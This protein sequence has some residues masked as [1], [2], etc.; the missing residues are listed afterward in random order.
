MTM[1]VTT[2]ALT[3]AMTPVSGRGC[4]AAA[5]PHEET[6]SR[7]TGPRVKIVRRFGGIDL[8]GLTRKTKWA[9]NRPFP[10]GQHGRNTRPG[11]KSDY[12]VRLEEKQKLR[13]YYG[14]R[15]RQLMRYMRQSV[16]A[17]GNTGENLLKVLESRLD[18]I[19]F[20]LGL[21]PTIPAARQ[22]V[23]HG[24]VTINGKKVDVASYRVKAGDEV[25]LRNK[26]KSQKLGAL[27]A[28]EP[29]L[30][31]PSHLE[32]DKK[33]LTGRVIDLPSRA[34]VPFELNEQLIVEYYSQRV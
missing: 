30:A 25:G 7:F 22:L 17:K 12:R 31:M 26:E 14:L 28:E 29:V 2:N 5:P 27:W 9:Q 19:I 21:S 23:N 33:T 34:A 13:F 6:M 24:H 4:R 18:N 32:F 20:R 16:K 11:K 3:I 10:P 15:E 8:P 1:V